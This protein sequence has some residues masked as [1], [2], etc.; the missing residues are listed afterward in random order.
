MKWLVPAMLALVALI[1]LA[2]LA[3]VLGVARMEAAYGVEI[4]GPDLAVLMRHRAVLF[5]LLGGFMLV[6]IFVRALQ[7]WALGIALLAAGAFVL[8][9][10]TTPATTATSPRSRWWTSPQWSSRWSD[11]APG[12]SSAGLQPGP[13]RC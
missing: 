8:L 6:A 10:W 12:G 11:W 3:G 7:P 1:H 5:G 13:E 4:A 9:A 2:P